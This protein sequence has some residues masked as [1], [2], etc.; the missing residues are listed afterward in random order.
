MTTD[1]NDPAAATG[2]VEAE[3]SGGVGRVMPGSLDRETLTSAL[4]VRDSA[5]GGSISSISTSGDGALGLGGGSSAPA[6]ARAMTFSAAARNMRTDDSGT[7]RASSCTLHLRSEV[8][9]TFLG[10]SG[11]RGT[12]G[13]DSSTTGGLPSL[14]RRDTIEAILGPPDELGPG[15]GDSSISTSSMRALSPVARWPLWGSTRRPSTL[16][17]TN[18]HV[19][20]SV[21]GLSSPVRLSRRPK[22]RFPV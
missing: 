1:R 9:E 6:P 5:V 13:G 4:A 2:T 3:A 16:V 7:I 8:I 18:P 20:R 22:G 17:N 11:K 10:S 19:V 14:G 12:G 21:A 15:V